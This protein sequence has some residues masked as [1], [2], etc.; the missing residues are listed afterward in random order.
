VAEAGDFLLLPGVIKSP[1]VLGMF[2]YLA[3]VAILAL[4]KLLSQK[5]IYSEQE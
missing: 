5:F 1:I 3:N 2:Q 4:N